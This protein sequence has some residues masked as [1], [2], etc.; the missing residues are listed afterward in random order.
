MKITWLVWPDHDE[1]EHLRFLGCSCAVLHSK[2]EGTQHGHHVNGWC[3]CLLKELPFKLVAR[4]KAYSVL[5]CVP[6][7]TLTEHVTRSPPRSLA[8]CFNRREILSNERFIDQ[9]EVYSRSR[10]NHCSEAL[11]CLFWCRLERGNL[12]YNFTV[13]RCLR[14]C[15][16]L[17]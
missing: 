2:G 6:W 15:T 9:N 3:E 10:E 7:T 1:D 14:W 16:W 11:R 4:L 5:I 17:D 12:G 13:L 8:I